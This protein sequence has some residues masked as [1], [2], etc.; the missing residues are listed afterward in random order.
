MGTGYTAGYWGKA[1]IGF[2]LIIK[3]VRCDRD[4]VDFALPLAHKPCSGFESLPGV[5]PSLGVQRGR[6]L[7]QLRLCF[8]PQATMGQFLDP[9]GKERE[10]EL[11]AKTRR[12]WSA[13]ALVLEIK[14]AGP[15]ERWQLFK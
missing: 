6:K 7:L 5:I 11:A 14:Q 1:F 8:G 4:L 2:S 9:E 3:A 12:C 10:H 15:V 13:K